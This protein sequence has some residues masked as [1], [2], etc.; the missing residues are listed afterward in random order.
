MLFLKQTTLEKDRYLKKIN[1]FFFIFFLFISGTLF[2]S[3]IESKLLVYNDSLKNSSLLFIQTDGKTIEEGVVY[4]GSERIKV[5]YEKPQRLTFVLSKK[6]GM[7]VNHELKEVQYF[8]PNKSFVKIFFKILR[9]DF[10][11]ENSYLNISNNSIL[12]KNNFEIMDRF[13][14]VDVIYENEPIKLRKIE[15]LENKE[16]FEI[17]FFN[18]NNLSSVNVDFSLI[19]P[20][21]R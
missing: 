4:I 3:D 20:Y 7:F 13:Y 12:I 5:E 10:F 21:L 1:Y 8:N 2:G 14:K 17:G 6:K 16:S 19:N 15:V 11:D 18:H 9:G